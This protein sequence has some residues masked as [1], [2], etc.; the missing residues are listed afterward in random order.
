MLYP[1]HGSV[2]FSVPALR[3]HRVK[4]LFD[5]NR[6]LTDGVGSFDDRSEDWHNGKGGFIKM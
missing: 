2:V 3:Y 1:A 6:D 4:I 5:V